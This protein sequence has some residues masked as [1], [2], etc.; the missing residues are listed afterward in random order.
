MQST[1]LPVVPITTLNATPIHLSQARIH[2]RAVS[3]PRTA[4]AGL[5]AVYLL[6][7]YE[8][9]I[10]GVNKLLNA[11]FA[12]GLGKELEDGLADNPNHWYV[13]L[14]RRFVLPHASAMALLVQWAELAVGLGLALGAVR[15]VAGARLRPNVAH[16]FDA[17]LLGALLGSA[18][19]ALNYWFMAGNTLP[20]VNAAHAFDEGI[21]L[22]GLLALGS[23]SLLALQV[24]ALRLPQGE[25]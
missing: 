11:D 15:L 20:W 22:D 1:D 19:M 12:S 10:S 24:R 23:F 5:A 6:V 25:M 21:S 17:A 2:D 7:A 4:A 16:L 13:H 14:V 3:A 8:W 18:V 9:L